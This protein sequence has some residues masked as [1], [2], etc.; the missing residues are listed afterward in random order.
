MKNDEGCKMNDDDSKL[1][2][3]FARGQTNGRT[4]ICDCRVAFAT[5]KLS[6]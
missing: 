2:K 5:E 3:V 1:L 6:Y 4:D